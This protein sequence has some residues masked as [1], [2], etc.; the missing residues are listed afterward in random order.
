M[1]DSWQILNWK[2]SSNAELWF[3]FQNSQDLLRLNC[4]SPSFHKLKKKR[5]KKPW[6]DQQFSV[7]TG[8]EHKPSDFKATE[9][10]F[11]FPSF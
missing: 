4:P 1:E 11:S 9:N 2:E 8:M 10:F 5:K 3:F 6:N 7:R